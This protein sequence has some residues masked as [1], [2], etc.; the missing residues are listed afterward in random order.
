[1]MNHANPNRS[2]QLARNVE[3]ALRF[4][5]K[6]GTPE[7]PQVE[8]EVLA[9]NYGRVCCGNLYLANNANGHGCPHPVMYCIRCFRAMWMSSSRRENISTCIDSL[10]CARFR[11]NS[12]TGGAIF[13][14]RSG[15]ANLCGSKASTVA[16]P[17]LCRRAQPRLGSSASLIASAASTP[18]IT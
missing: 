7:M 4:K 10:C 12:V 8:K 1:M 5:Q 9:P 16:E 2:G 15:S 11:R 3:I 17:L 18:P 14:L 13:W 6:Q